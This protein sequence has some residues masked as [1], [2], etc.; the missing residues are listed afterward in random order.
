MLARRVR[1]N[2]IR[3]WWR[4]HYLRFKRGNGPSNTQH[5][6]TKKQPAKADRFGLIASMRLS[7][8]TCIGISA[9]RLIEAEY[10]ERAW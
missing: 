5:T 2:R 6:H 9:L 3:M 4:A 1:L 8:Q 7:E 10:R